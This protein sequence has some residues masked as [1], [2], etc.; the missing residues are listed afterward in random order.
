MPASFPLAHCDV[1][2]TPYAKVGRGREVV[3]AGV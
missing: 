1:T 3:D 2:I